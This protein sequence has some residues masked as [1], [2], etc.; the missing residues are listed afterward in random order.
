MHTSY[1]SSCCV[2]GISIYLAQL[3]QFQKDARGNV[4][5]K[6]VPSHRNSPAHCEV[7]M[8][9]NKCNGRYVCASVYKD[10]VINWY[11]SLCWYY[12]Y[13]IHIYVKRKNNRIV[14]DLVN[15]H[16]YENKNSLYFSVHKLKSPQFEKPNFLKVFG[17]IQTKS[18]KQDSGNRLR[19]SMPGGDQ[20]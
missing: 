18:P 13:V 19:S 15:Q 16:Y 1:L 20:L 6:I 12:T 17:N 8:Q 7:C 5:L 14:W 9:E 11:L 3:T 10:F 4:C 2:V